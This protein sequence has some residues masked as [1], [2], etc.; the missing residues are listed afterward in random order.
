MVY[1]ATG[2][3]H[4]LDSD[5]TGSGSTSILSAVGQLPL[6]FIIIYLLDDAFRVG[7]YIQAGSVSGGLRKRKRKRPLLRETLRACLD[8]NQHG[9]TRRAERSAD[10]EFYRSPPPVFE[11]QTGNRRSLF[12]VYNPQQHNLPSFLQPF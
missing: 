12:P 4:L 3:L 5:E 10:S 11:I 1:K 7:E 9:W 8:I 6:D 2:L